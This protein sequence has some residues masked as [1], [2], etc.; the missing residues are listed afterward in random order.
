MTN[1]NIIY[2][3]AITAKLYTQ[4]ELDNLMQT[5]GDL[6]LHTYQEWRHIGLNVKA[7]EKAA[8]TTMLWR[9]TS[10]SKTHGDDALSQAAEDQGDNHYYLAKA[11]LFTAAQ[12][13]KPRAVH[14]KTAD[15]L[16]AYNEMLR[17][18]RQAHKAAAQTT[19]APDTTAPAP[20]NYAAEPVQLCFA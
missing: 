6:P 5:T 13:E 20:A 16:R 18:Q 14:V 12:V 2:N 17:Q 10:A 19:A 9:H 1:N 15:E 7:G 3:A 8:I 4:A 11:H